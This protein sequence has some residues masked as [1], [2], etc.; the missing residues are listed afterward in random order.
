MR[1]GLAFVLL[2]I[3]AVLGL[4]LRFTNP[5][6]TETQLLIELWP[7]WLGLAILGCV[8][9]ALVWIRHDDKD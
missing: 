9:L 8:A 2:L 3:G 4:W 1:R 5:Q 7:Q 6:L